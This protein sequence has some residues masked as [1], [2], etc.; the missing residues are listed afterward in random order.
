MTKYHGKDTYFAVDDTGATLRDLSASCDNV[1]FPRSRAAD[2]D[3]TFGQG[4]MSSKAGLRST[5][6]RISGKFND[7]ANDVDEVLDALLQYD[8]PV[9][10]E[11]GPSG[12]TAGRVKYSGTCLCTSY[13]PS[14]PVDGVVTFTAEFE[15]QEDP[16]RGTF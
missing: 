8:T 14:S 15:V 11:Y 6:I 9:D 5:T 12:N 13:T 16:T 4:H 3:T 2:D 7:A 10:Y 1:D